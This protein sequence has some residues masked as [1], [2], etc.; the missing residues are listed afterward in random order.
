MKNGLC[1]AAFLT[2]ACSAALCA[3][4]HGLK[5]VSNKNPD[6][7]NVETVLKDILKP[8]MSDQQKCEAIFN[9]LVVHF[10]HFY[11]TQE[12]NADLLEGRKANFEVT[13]LEDAVKQL[14]VYAHG[15]CGSQSKISCQFYNAAG[16]LSRV[17][18]VQGHTTF[19][20][21]YD[22]AWHYFDVDM[23]GFVRNPEGKVVSIDQIKANKNLLM[24]RHKHTPKYFFKFDGPRTMYRALSQGVRF[25][26]Y[27]RK[28]GV[29]SMNLSLK[30][31]EVF[32]RYF[33]RQWAP[34]YRYYCPPKG[35]AHSNGLKQVKEGPSRDKA[36]YLF[37]E[38]GLKRYGNWERIYTPD[39]KKKS[40]LNAAFS[41]SNVKSNTEKPLIAS[42]KTGP[43]QIIMN[44]YSPYG[45][46]GVAGDLNTN[47]DDKKG[48]VLEGEFNTDSGEISFSFDLGKSWVSAHKGGGAFKLDLTPKFVAKYGW[49]LKISFEGNKAG[50]NSFTSY[51]SGQ[52]SPA[53]LPFVDG[54]TEMTFS[55]EGTDCMLLQPDVGISAENFKLLA[56]KVEGLTWSEDGIAHLNGNGSVIYKVDAPG[57]ITRVQAGAKFN[58]RKGLYKMEF[59]IDDGATWILAGKQK[60]VYSEDHNEEFW[61][62]S[63]EGIIDFELKKAYSP[64]C[65]KAKGNQW[66]SSFDPKPVKSILVKFSQQGGRLCKIYGIYTHFKKEGKVP[67][68]ITHTWNGGKHIE[69]VEA[70][71]DE[72]KYTVNGGPLKDN[73]SISFE[74]GE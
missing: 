15:L 68:T 67:V 30:D 44:V 50:L 4:G 2:V 58:G 61:G 8:G 22:D 46:A 6:P 57:D 62:Q 56:H 37:T 52:L 27:G 1:T 39:L 51:T 65:I 64:G 3:G 5:V 53:S 12:A 10:Y 25:A 18:G 43:S 47:E 13:M 69:K 21:K 11:V 35:C 59:S 71:A 49:L 26:M 60:S 29:H 31:G 48:Y 16:F 70:Q 66:E 55:R 23:M 63:L 20:V 7:S 34:E 73:L 54:N 45:C 40:F 17:C 36:H 38:A 41:K 32:T 14:N 72:K 28:I 33:Q 9:Y 74:A 42:E 24:K 19:E